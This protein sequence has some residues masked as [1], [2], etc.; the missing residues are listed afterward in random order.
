MDPIT[1]IIIAIAIISIAAAAAAAFLTPKL[2]VA[3]TPQAGEA[4]V[5]LASPGTP[6]PVAFGTVLFNA[7]NVVDYGDLK[8]EPILSS[9]AS[10]GK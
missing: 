4:Q 8:T 1:W 10:G 5:S 3:A 6:I 7:A 9:T 2:P